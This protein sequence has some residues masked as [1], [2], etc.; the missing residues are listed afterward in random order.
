MKIYAI[1]NQ[2]GKF[3]R[4]KQVRSE[5]EIQQYLE[6][7]AKDKKMYM[8]IHLSGSTRKIDARKLHKLE[9]VIQKEKRHLNVKD[10]KDLK[11]LVQVLK[12]RP[13]R[14]GMIVAGVLDTAIRDL[15][16]AEVWEA[17]GGEVHKK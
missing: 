16:P 17:M 2:Y 8:A 12:Q 11:M 9:L 7:N 4:E 10:L 15:I 13:A 14:Y 3:L 5:S 1:Y 6:R